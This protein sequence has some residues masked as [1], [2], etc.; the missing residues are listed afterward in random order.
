M[1]VG[2]ESLDADHQCLLDILNR[3]DVAI[4]AGTGSDAI[5][6]VLDRL[7]DYVTY[8]FARE[9]RLM[10]AAG[11]PDLDTHMR[12]HAVLER[13]I[14]DIRQRHL[15]NPEAIRDR[16]V[17]GFLVAWLTTHIMGR[18]KLYAPFLSGNPAAAADSG[19]GDADA[20]CADPGDGLAPPTRELWVKEPET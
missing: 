6:G 9:E 12:A 14:G 17:L 19:A 11:Y 8:H 13:Q 16:A 1:S 15:G 20:A 2:V 10:R 18:D 3:L 5:A 7:R 4:A